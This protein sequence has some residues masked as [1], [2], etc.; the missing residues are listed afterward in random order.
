MRIQSIFLVSLILV[1]FDTAHAQVTTEEAARI[2]VEA[3]IYGYPL[4][5]V[6]MTR[7][8]MTNVEKPESLRGPMNVFLN[9]RTYPSAAF[10]DVTAPNA[11]TLYSSAWLN[12]AEEP[13]ILS[14]PDANDR[15]YLMPMLSGWTDVFE[16]PGK[17]TTGTKAQTY[18]LTGP[19]WKGTLPEGL[20]ELKSPTSLVWILGRTYCTGTTQDY[21]EVHALQDKY[22][23]VPLSS[24][25]KPYTP[26]TGKVDHSID[27]LT[28]VREQV[29][30]MEITT[31]F[32][33]LALLMK[34]NPPAAADASIVEKM[35]RIGV[36]PGKPF[37]ISKLPPAA[38]KSLEA[39]PKMAQ[40]LILDHF[41]QAGR[42]VNGWRVMTN[43]GR[44]GTDYLQRAFITAIGLGANRPQDAVYPTST[45]DTEGK[46][47]DGANRYVLHFE[48]G[49]MPPVK[50]FWSL[51]MYDGDYFFVDNPLNRYTVSSRYDLKHNED[52]SVDLYI[53]KNSPGQ[54]KESNW[55]PAPSGKFILMMRLY[56]PR[57]TTPSIIDGTWKPPGV[58]RVN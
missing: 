21:E 50:G 13:Y 27:M 32:N 57:E 1:C 56:W 6:D 58:Q 20:R 45:T 37:D 26:P 24:H 48:K 7:K 39:V 18:A 51:T 4:V 52:G 25:G 31:Y 8:V 36:V 33:A 23:L 12:L 44:Y 28:P 42:D 54:G 2:G 5:T 55:L 46:L 34:D 19:D 17:R 15:Y 40:K 14:L 30:R 38:A 16:V 11:D 22:S 41:L 35:A 43:T 3:Y 9:A 29:D 10:R 47:Y 53:Q 49:L